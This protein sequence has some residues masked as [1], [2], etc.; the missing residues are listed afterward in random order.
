MLT[1]KKREQRKRANNDQMKQMTLLMYTSMANRQLQSC[2]YTPHT[3]QMNG[4]GAGGGRDR[5]TDRQQQRDTERGAE[6]ESQ[7][8]VTERS[9]KMSSN[10][11]GNSRRIWR[12]IH[13]FYT[14][15]TCLGDSGKKIPFMSRT[16]GGQKV[17]AD[18]G[19]GWTQ[20]SAGEVME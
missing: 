16:V 8:K 4:E 12:A 2:I 14:R 5:Q 9:E 7:R 3:Q 1:F 10:L 15:P 18:C 11:T 19:S 20:V 6:T 13:I 17:P